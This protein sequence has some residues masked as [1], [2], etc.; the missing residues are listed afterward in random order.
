LADVP[1]VAGAPPGA[2]AALAAVSPGWAERFP[3]VADAAGPMPLGRALSEVVR[4][5]AEEHPVVLAVDDAHWLDAE[6]AGAFAAL[7][8]D[9]AGMP[10]TLALALSPLPPRPDLDDLRSRIGRDLAGSVVEVG[11]L[12]ASA[13]RF[14][15][16]QLLPGYDAIELDR[17]ARRVGTDSAGLPLLA[18]ELLR[19]VA[20][21][22]DLQ[23]TPGAWPA[24]HKTLDQTLPGDLPDAVVAAIRIGFRRL[25]PD[26]Q[27]VL[28]AVAVLGDRVAPDRAAAAL[29]L[30]LDATHAALDEL[31]WHHWLV[32]EPRGYAFVA[33]LVR[34][35]VER[36]MLM[37][38]QRR[39]LLEAD[40]P[41][42]SP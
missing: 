30:P 7:L 34:L 29:G 28:T 17:V 22:L 27:R 4:V 6:S 35:V 37:P 36:D 19:A 2:L 11:P 40:H 8:R 16:E 3:G 5:A 18:V 25:T 26:A 12:S 10:V 20:A 42:E 38:G 23:Q 41:P 32:A 1:G 31:E 33:R 13:L 24:P 21:G 14:L 15:A 39:R 9:L